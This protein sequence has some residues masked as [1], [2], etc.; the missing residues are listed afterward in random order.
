MMCFK[1]TKQDTRMF[2]YLLYFVK[3]KCIWAH[4]SKPPN[5]DSTFKMESLR[6]CGKLQG[7]QSEKGL[8]GKMIQDEQE[9]GN[10]L[11]TLKAQGSLNSDGRMHQER[12]RDFCIQV[13]FLL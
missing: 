10:F 6:V 2:R 12:D 5:E 8:E 4:F 11:K 3:N 9:R 13:P 1:K 7:C